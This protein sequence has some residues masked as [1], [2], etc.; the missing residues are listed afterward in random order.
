MGKGLSRHAEAL[1]YAERAA[2][3]E[4]NNVNIL[5]TLGYLQFQVGDADKAEKTF[6]RARAQTIDSMARFMPTLHLLEIKLK[7]NDREKAEQ[8]F[9]EVEE[10]YRRDPRIKR[11]NE[12]EMERIR[13]LMPST[14]QP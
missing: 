9:K 2:E 4:P 10:M 13:K 5:D 7:K 11:A 14:P 6:E 3:A 12:S 1:P 8:L